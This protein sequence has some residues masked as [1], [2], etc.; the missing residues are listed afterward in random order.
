[1]KKSW[2][3]LN[4]NQKV[5]SFGLFCYLIVFSIFIRIGL[6]NCPMLKRC[7][8]PLYLTVIWPLG[9]HNM[10][11]MWL[12]HWS[13]EWLLLKFTN[14]VM[15]IAFASEGNLLFAVKAGRTWMKEV[16]P[17]G[18]YGCTVSRSE[19]QITANQIHQ[20]WCERGGITGLLSC[21]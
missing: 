7:S 15:I 12:F 20:T 17:W 16:F 5:R 19:E 8:P 9:W 4:N 14:C 18:H 3:E 2:K 11:R 21:G 1:M 10:S 13:R 6:T